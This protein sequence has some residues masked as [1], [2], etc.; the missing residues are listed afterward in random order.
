[1]RFDFKAETEKI[2]NLLKQDK[3]MLLTVMLGVLGV[4]LI[5]S[6]GSDEKKNIKTETADSAFNEV[7]TLSEL[8]DFLGSIY[9]AGKVKVMITYESSGEEV[10]A[11]DYETKENEKESD[12]KEEYIIID[13]GS[14]ENGLKLKS[15]YPKVKGVAVA[16][17]GAENPVI[18]E[19]IISVVS[20]LFDISSN[21]ISVAIMK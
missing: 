15:I 17:Q 18:R 10:F 20:A 4:I 16:C 5:F 8:E 3:K 13:S 11:K 7:K 12:K 14:D 9:G 1:M 21:S 2:I 19:Q 6:S